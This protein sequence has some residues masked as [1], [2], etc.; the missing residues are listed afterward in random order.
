MNSP[1]ILEGTAACKLRDA[2]LIAKREKRVTCKQITDHL[3]KRKLPKWLQ[4][5]ILQM[6]AHRQYERIT[7]PVEQA[8]EAAVHVHIIKE[9]RK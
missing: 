7:C 1:L 8:M 3:S 4:S 9:I 5:Q 6:A 2:L